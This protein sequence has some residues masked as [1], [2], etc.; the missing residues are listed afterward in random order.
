MVS[1]DCWDGVLNQRGII[2][3]AEIFHFLRE[4]PF[5]IRSAEFGLADGALAMNRDFAPGSSYISR[6]NTVTDVSHETRL[7]LFDVK[8]KISRIAGE[9]IYITTVRQRSKVAF[10]LGYCVADPQYVEII[11]NYQQSHPY[12]AEPDGDGSREVAVNRA[13]MSRFPHHVYG[14]DPSNAPYRLPLRMLRRTLNQMRDD[15]LNGRT[16]VNPWTMVPYEGWSPAETI[17]TDSLMPGELSSGLFS[18]FEAVMALNHRISRSPESIS[19]DLMWLQPFVADFKFIL[20]RKQYFVQHKLDGRER[21]RDT[22]LTK[23]AICRGM[24]PRRKWYFSHRDM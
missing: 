7:L 23:V 10:Y 8:S 15:L 21:A 14:L 16:F 6:L 20:D 5:M 12:E 24:E 22:P 19:L 1:L 4:V 2:H 9:Q 11:P 3:E 17:S 13:K 18:A